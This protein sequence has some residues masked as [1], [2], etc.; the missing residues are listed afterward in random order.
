MDFDARETFEDLVSEVLAELEK[1]S[2]ADRNSVLFSLIDGLANAGDLARARHLAGPLEDSVPSADNHGWIAKA[3]SRS[4]RIQE[5]KAIADSFSKP[6]ARRIVLGRIAEGLAERG[7]VDEAMEIARSIG[8][9]LF[10]GE[11]EDFAVEYLVEIADVAV[12]LERPEVAEEAEEMGKEMHGSY[13]DI[14]QIQMLRASEAIQ[15]GDRGAGAALIDQA[16]DRLDMEGRDTKTFGSALAYRTADRLGASTQASRASGM[17][18]DAMAQREGDARAWERGLMFTVR[19]QASFGEVVEAMESIDGIADPNRKVWAML[20]LAYMMARRNL[21]GWET[22]LER[23]IGAA[24]EL[25]D[26]IERAKRLANAVTVIAWHRS[27][28]L[29]VPCSLTT[30]SSLG[31]E[32]GPG[33][34]TA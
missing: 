25:T 20:C 24:R 15:G 34:A 13:F 12:K 17:Y 1:V 5:A 19:A 14:V 23:C 30:L 7:D 3:H 2:E 26:P 27:T 21:V 29:V 10:Q 9:E 28:S 16:L 11:D 22:L 8:P 32:T 6:A 31:R 18:L 33:V 4:G